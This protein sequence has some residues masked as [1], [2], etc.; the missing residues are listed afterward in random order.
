[1]IQSFRVTNVG[2]LRELASPTSLETSVLVHGEN[3]TGKSTLAAIFRSFAKNESTSIQ[4]RR[5]VGLES[6]PQVEI[7]FADEKYSFSDGEW[8]DSSPNMHV[9]DQA[10]VNRNVHS[11][12][13]MDNDHGKNLY[14]IILGEAC[15]DR[16]EEAAEL[17]GTVDEQN[18]ELRGVTKE[19]ESHV[20]RGL[21]LEEFIAL[22]KSSS[23]DEE[24]Q[25]QEERIETLRQSKKLDRAKKFQTIELPTLSDSFAGVLKKNISNFLDNAE[26]MV[27]EHVETK[28]E[29]ASVAWIE[30]GSEFS[31]GKDCPFCGSSLKK[32]DLISAY[33]SFFSRDYNTLK[34]E[35]NTLSGLIDR[36]YGERIVVNQQKLLSEND[37]SK[38][39][40]EDYIDV[41]PLDETI[42]EEV[43]DQLGRTREKLNDLAERKKQNPLDEIEMDVD[44]EFSSSLQDRID[45]Y[46]TLVGVANERIDELKESQAKE[47]LDGEVAKLAALKASSI[48]F[49]PEVVELIDD[50]KAATKKKDQLAKQRK[51]LQKAIQKETTEVFT[52]RG[53]LINELLKSF[54]TGFTLGE[55][56]TNNRTKP[57]SVQI[58]VCF[59]DADSVR[60]DDK[61]SK[62]E[63]PFEA[64]LSSGERNILAFALFLTNLTKDPM[65]GEKV[66]VVDDP[67]T[68]LDD[69]RLERMAEVVASISKDAKQLLVLSHNDR[70]LDAVEKSSKEE[71]QRLSLV[72]DG[73]ATSLS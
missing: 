73:I 33:K 66:V 11:G 28:T 55:F 15:G 26:Q 8:S 57:P 6:D 68:N 3:G 47:D 70:F 67:V 16:L 61:A 41:P 2:S 46:N 64:A 58:R 25:R 37:A 50:W 20:P 13:L 17:Q 62:S 35:I 49:Q 1:M 4:D 65:I 10:F 31:N 63:R 23:L 71:S 72:R 42:F 24:I 69:R 27:L 38:Q 29:G 59:E 34:A 51:D 60:L 53:E 7:D 39:F 54:D 30:Q 18:S 21:Q 36:A 40:W 43:D 9:F 5:T 19:L 32:N 56:D 44:L 14:A 22:K 48:R 45:D 52:S 12:D